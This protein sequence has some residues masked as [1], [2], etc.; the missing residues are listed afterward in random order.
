MPYLFAGIEIFENTKTY[1][2]RE[3][4]Q[5]LHIDYCKKRQFSEDV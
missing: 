4:S 2:F 1:N 5:K 3:K